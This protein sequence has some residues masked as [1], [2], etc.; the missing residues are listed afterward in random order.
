[1]NGSKPLFL[2]FGVLF[3]LLISAA[4]SKPPVWD[5]D[6]RKGM[7]LYKASRYAEAAP[8][9]QKVGLALPDDFAAQ[10]MLGKCLMNAGD[11]ASA[12]EPLQRAWLLKPGDGETAVRVVTIFVGLKRCEEALRQIRSRPIATYAREYRGDLY[13]LEGLASWNLKNIPSAVEAFRN[14]DSAYAA[15]ESNAGDRGRGARRAE[16]LSGLVKLLNLQARG[17]NGGEREARYAESLGRAEILITLDPSFENLLAAAEAALGS[18]QDVRTEDLARRASSMAP[19]SGFAL[20]YL[21]QAL[22]RQQRFAEAVRPLQDAVRL[23]PAEQR[24]SAYNQLGMALEHLKRAD[25]ALEAYRRAGNTEGV[26]RVSEHRKDGNPPPDAA[27][28]AP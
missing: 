4:R 8:F 21:G 11:S 9:F 17:L 25:Q 2:V 14:A 24:R 12:L 1:M 18:R 7:D 27:Q 20:F 13:R 19:D 26:K 6:W 10:S 22:S 16:V 5:E 23:L 15:P 28:T 3:L